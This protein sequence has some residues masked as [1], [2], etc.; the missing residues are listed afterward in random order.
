MLQEKQTSYSRI[1]YKWLTIIILAVGVCFVAAPIVIGVKHRDV[2][3]EDD[4]YKAG[5]AYDE[6]LKKHSQLGW[7]VE[8][9]D[10]VKAGESIFTVRITDNKGGGVEPLEVEFLLQNIGTPEVLTYKAFYNG[11]GRYSSP[12]RLNKSGYWDV[13]VKVKTEKDNYRF[14]RKFYAE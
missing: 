4:P 13:R 1:N 5:L 9:P 12:V 2:V 7:N 10:K 3:V 14:D 8:C 6:T 11:E